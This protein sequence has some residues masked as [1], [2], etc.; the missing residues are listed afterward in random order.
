MWTQA[1][2]INITETI[3]SSIQIIH[4]SNKTE[5]VVLLIKN[6]LSEDEEDIAQ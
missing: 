6:N 4:L 5:N 3:T 1:P 2:R